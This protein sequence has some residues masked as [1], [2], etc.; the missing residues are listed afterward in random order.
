MSDR[1]MDMDVDQAWSNPQPLGINDLVAG[2][3]GLAPRSRKGD[4]LATLHNQRMP[5]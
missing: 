3:F 1:T 2:S 5:D 4:D